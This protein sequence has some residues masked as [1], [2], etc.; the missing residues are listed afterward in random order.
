MLRIQRA[1]RGKIGEGSTIGD[2]VT[3]AH[4]EHRPIFQDDAYHAVR[5]D[6]RATNVGDGHGHDGVMVD[7]VD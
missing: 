7:A 3:W 1:T 5:R 4:L 2:R 6:G